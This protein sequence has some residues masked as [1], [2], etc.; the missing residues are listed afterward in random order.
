MSNS[1][2]LDDVAL[3][4]SG[5]HG[6]SSRRLY[7]YLSGSDND[8]DDDDRGGQGASRRHVH[9]R[10]RDGDW[11]P[12]PRAAEDDEEEDE[13]GVSSP[14]WIHSGTG[15]ESEGEPAGRGRGV[16]DGTFGVYSRI[17]NLGLSVFMSVCLSRACL[18]AVQKRSNGARCCLGVEALEKPRHILFMELP[19]PLR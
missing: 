16:V 13:G 19:M 6:D 3:T 9:A 15:S 1:C 5:G 4:Q 18:C 12:A 14:S 10:R 7:S 11:R 17:N 8:D 2:V